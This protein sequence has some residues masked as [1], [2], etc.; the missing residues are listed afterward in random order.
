MYP[1]FFSLV[2]GKPRKALE[3]SHDLASVNGG[4]FLEKCNSAVRRNSQRQARECVRS[5]LSAGGWPSADAQQI[6]LAVKFGEVV[7]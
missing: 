2:E 5:A 3:I 6:S 1:K 7:E 4:D